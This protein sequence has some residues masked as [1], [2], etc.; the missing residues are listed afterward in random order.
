MSH[1][2][3]QLP[4]PPDYLDTLQQFLHLAMQTAQTASAEG[5]HR[6]VLQAI[7]EG[8]R[9]IAL[10]TKM[11]SCLT[12]GKALETRSALIPTRA[13]HSGNSKGAAPTGKWEKSGKNAAKIPLLGNILA[14]FQ[15]DS[16]SKKSSGK[17]SQPGSKNVN[18][19]PSKAASSLSLDA[20]PD[21][22]DSLLQEKELY[23]FCVKAFNSDTLDMEALMAISTGKTCSE[24]GEVAKTGSRSHG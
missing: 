10:I 19:A 7:R 14:L 2:E 24:H 4:R 20:G 18:P 16:K 9:I 21:D 8:T 15:H 11:T 5:N 22:L 17:N 13:H 1:P 6:L 12:S 3:T 23:D